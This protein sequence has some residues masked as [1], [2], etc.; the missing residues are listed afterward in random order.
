[1]VGR[2]EK[3]K[4]AQARMHLGQSCLRLENCYLRVLSSIDANRPRLIIIRRDCVRL[5]ATEDFMASQCMPRPRPCFKTIS[6]C[7]QP[8]MAV[9]NSA[10]QWA[11][12]LRFVQPG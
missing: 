7:R 10:T 1:M 12:R 6:A 2:V 11:V 5:I 9:R 4:K 8:N 3:K